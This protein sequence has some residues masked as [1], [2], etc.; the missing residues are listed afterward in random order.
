MNTHVHHSQTESPRL[1][2]SWGKRD[3]AR[4]AIRRLRKK[5]PDS[6]MRNELELESMEAA[7]EEARLISSESGW[8][9]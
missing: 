8:L 4:A 9:E 7:V 2:V 3:E 1:L 5:L 6:D